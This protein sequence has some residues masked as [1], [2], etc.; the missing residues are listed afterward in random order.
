MMS[1]RGIH[2]V[3]IVASIALAVMVTVWGVAMYMSDRG[4]WGHLAFAAGSLSSAGGMAIYLVGFARKSRAI[5][6]R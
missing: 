4:T 5:G 2:L 6:M 3:F 1:L